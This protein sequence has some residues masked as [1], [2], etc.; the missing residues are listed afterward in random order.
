M[1]LKELRPLKRV[2]KDLNTFDLQFYV[3]SKKVANA[4]CKIREKH[5]DHVSND[6]DGNTGREIIT[7]CMGGSWYYVSLKRLV[8]DLL[9]WGYKVVDAFYQKRVSKKGN[10]YFIVRFTFARHDI[11]DTWYH[12]ESD[13]YKVLNNFCRFSWRTKIYLNPYYKDNQ[14]LEGKYSMS[15]KLTN[16][17]LKTNPP[18]KLVVQGY[19]VRQI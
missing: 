4:G 1:L 7:S 9:H 13:I 17:A 12:P 11:N 10:D 19:E 2:D 8:K 15:A 6:S 3:E 14:R 5:D 18:F 16:R